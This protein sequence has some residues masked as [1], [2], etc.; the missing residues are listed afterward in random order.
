MRV[1]IRQYL[2]SQKV[3][4]FKKSGI[5]GRI[6]HKGQQVLA[7]YLGNKNKDV[8]PEDSSDAREELAMELLLQGQS[9]PKFYF[10]NLSFL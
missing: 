2:K 3:L 8:K 10:K 6:S 5:R 4:G 9:F 7:C 1:A